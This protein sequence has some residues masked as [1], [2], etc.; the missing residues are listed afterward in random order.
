MSS[1]L[2]GGND[3]SVDFDVVD[4]IKNGFPWESYSD[5]SENDIDSRMLRS[6]KSVFE[7]KRTRLVLHPGI[8]VDVVPDKN[9]TL[10]LNIKKGELISK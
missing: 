10:M 4:E 6:I 2:A 3:V 5:M 1:V 7:G 8:D 9:G